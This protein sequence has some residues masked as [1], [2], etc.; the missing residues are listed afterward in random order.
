MSNI[1][2]NFFQVHAYTQAI[3]DFNNIIPDEYSNKKKIIEIS[4]QI[5]YNIKYRAPEI[6]NNYYLEEIMKFI[7]LLPNDER[8]DSWGS[9]SWN[10]L[11]DAYHNAHYSSP[12]IP[13]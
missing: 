7:H 2:G 12:I 13:S 6:M 3:Q 4:K 10:I 5:L 8:Y 1:I 9:K 11:T